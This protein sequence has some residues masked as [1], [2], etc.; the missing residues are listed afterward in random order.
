MRKAIVLGILAILTAVNVNAQ[1]PHFT[2]FYANQLYLNPAFAGSSK[3][4]K[5]T[6]GYRNQFP[7][8]A[9]DFVTYSLSYDQHVSS[10]HG[11]LGL[12]VISDQ[13]GQGALGITEVSGIYSYQLVINQSFSILAGF[14]GTYRQRSLDWSKLT[15]PDQIDDMY[16]FVKP[17]EEVAPNEPT[18]SHV[19]LSAGIIGF[20]DFFY[21]GA[22][23]HH[24]TEPDEAFLEEGILPRRLT[25]HSGAIIPLSGNGR[26]GDKK[27][28]SPNVLYYKQQ[29]FEQLNLGLS[30][31]RNEIGAGFWFRQN[32]NNADAIMLIVG[33]QP[34]NF[35]IG[36]SYDFTISKLGPTSGGAHEVSFSYQ[37][38]CSPK[39]RKF[40]TINCPSF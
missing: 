13:A 39:K 30:V 40:K 16:G 29:D 35:R 31:Q 38:E 18:I 26:V 2:Q 24:I 33:Y 28:I 27:F 14:Q 22:A 9:A 25:L 34:D 23:M 17:T 11:G 7:N 4:P 8:I 6:L 10:L 15:F 20:S 12:M 1:D 19:D 5:V 36:Y 3:C 32:F 21:I 37:F